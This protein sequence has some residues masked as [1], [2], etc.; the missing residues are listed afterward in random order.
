MSD[1]PAQDVEER[2]T[3]EPQHFVLEVQDVVSVISGGLD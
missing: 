3:E 1:Q 2:D